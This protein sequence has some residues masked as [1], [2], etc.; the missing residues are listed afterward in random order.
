MKKTLVVLV[1]VFLAAIGVFGF[2]QIGKSNSTQPNI[3]IC[4][5]D[6]A[7]FPHMGVYGSKLVITPGFDEIANRGLLFTNAYTPNAKC[8]PSRAI[9]LTGR[10]SWQL[11]EAANHQCYFPAKYKSFFEIL[12]QN[13]YET[14]YTGKGWGPG[15][16]IDKAG[17]ER[18]LTGKQYNQ[19]KLKPPTPHI[20]TIDYAA[21]FKKFLRSKKKDKPFCFWYGALEPHRAYE[22]GSGMEKGGK[23]F[24]DIDRVYSFWPKTERVKNDMLDYALEV[25]HFDQHLSEII[26]FLE[27]EKILENTIVIVTSDHG[28]PFPRIK[29]Q[30]YP[31]SNHVPFSMMWLKGLKNPGRVIDDFVN[32]SDVAPTLLQL[33]GIPSIEK[34]MHI[35][36]GKS[37]VDIL[38]SPKSGWIDENR[39]FAI[40]GKERHDVGRPNDAG[41]P[42]RGIITANF[43]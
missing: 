18:E 34:Q 16:A 21:N 13:G 17:I 27:E 12:E 42:I 22:Y 29:G 2:W 7:S 41:Y 32:F 40:I 5:A 20:S 15:I 31:H 43:L 35:F 37:F 6:D 39:D 11:E 8:A 30:A 23:S 14:G 26:R 19:I 10:Y 9:F 3:L 28:M 1:S 25:E 36:G 38:E 4:I 33:T 24:R